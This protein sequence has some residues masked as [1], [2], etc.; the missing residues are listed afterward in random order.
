MI[1]DGGESGR[2]WVEDDDKYD[3]IEHTDRSLSMKELYI[4]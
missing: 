4:M 3:C 1:L 2:E